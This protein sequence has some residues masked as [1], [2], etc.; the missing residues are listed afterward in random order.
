MR[1]ISILSLT[2]MLFCINLGWTADNQ[3][4]EETRSQIMDRCTKYLTAIKYR[5]WEEAYSYISSRMNKN[6]FMERMK[7]LAE[8]ED[9]T[10]AYKLAGFSIDKV[11]LNESLDEA[12]VWLI[13]KLS[14]H[15][16]AFG[17]TEVDSP[18]VYLWK[19]EADGQ[20]YRDYGN[21]KQKID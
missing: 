13:E 2:I 14:V 1:K 20:W 17:W 9:N 8:G 5:N 10:P 15:K 11:K 12:E 16:D 6:E 21:P 18:Q 4:R 7:K 3:E 19:K